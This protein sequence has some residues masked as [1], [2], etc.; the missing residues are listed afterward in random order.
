MTQEDM[1]REKYGIQDE[2]SS[3]FTA[4]LYGVLVGG[5]SMAAVVGVLL[6]GIRG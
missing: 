5:L 1:F 4:E 3:T 2:G 6:W